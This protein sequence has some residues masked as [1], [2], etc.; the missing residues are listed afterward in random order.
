[1][2]DLLRGVKSGDA[3]LFPSR[4]QLQSLK[5][6]LLGFL[7]VVAF[8]GLVRDAEGVGGSRHGDSCEGSPSLGRVRGLARGQSDYSRWDRLAGTY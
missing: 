4:S 1:M 2:E 8:M 3:S 6:V 7:F 5:V